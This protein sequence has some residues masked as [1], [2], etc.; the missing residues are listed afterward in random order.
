MPAL[1]SSARPSGRVRF[2]ALWFAV[3]LDAMR[4]GSGRRLRIRSSLVAAALLI[5][6]VATT[7]T[8]APSGLPRVRV[9]ADVRTAAGE[10]RGE[11]TFRVRASDGEVVFALF[12]NRF[13]DDGE[14]VNDMTRYYVYPDGTF[15]PGGIEILAV[16][17]RHAGG[18]WQ[19]VSSRS[20]V[21]PPWASGEDSLPPDTFL[22]VSSGSRDSIRIRFRTTLPERYGPFGRTE[23]G[24]T[25]IG[26]WYPSLVA[27]D[28]AG[29]WRF[30]RPPAL[31][32]T[33]A[34]LTLDAER[35]VVL[36][37]RVFAPSTTAAAA[38][39]TAETAPAVAGE[40][41]TAVREVKTR[42]LA[43][44]VYEQAV[45]T[46]AA[47]AGVRLEFASPEPHRADRIGFGPD[48]P[49]V[50][51]TQI[52]T[53][54]D[55]AP[56]A[57][58]RP[59]ALTIAQV[60]L[61][62]NLTTIS[63][64][65]VV[66]SDRA[67]HVHWLIRTFHDAQIAQAVY[68]AL[69][70]PR[71]L[72]CEAPGDREWVT[73][74]IAWELSRQFLRATE[75]RHE[76]TRK[77]IERLGIFAIVDRFER[78]PK[79]PFTTAFFENARSRDELRQSVFTWTQT[80]APAALAL[81][82]LDRSLG[83]AVVEEATRRWVEA[84]GRGCLPFREALREAAGSGTSDTHR[85]HAPTGTPPPAPSTS[86]NASV[87]SDASS[88]PAVIEARSVAEELD[89]ALAPPGPV[90]PRTRVDLN[91]APRTAR[92]RYQFVLDSADVDIS[93]SE[94]G[95]TALFNFR[96]RGNYRRGFALQ[97]WYTEK[98]YGF[99]TG[100]HLHW[101]TPND[102]SSYRHNLFA[103]YQLAEL[104]PSFTAD[105]QPD[106]RDNG[107]VAGFGLR[108][109][110]SDAWWHDNPTDKRQFRIFFDGYDPSLGG[111]W[112]FLRWGARARA[113]TTL[114]SPNTVLAGEL[115]T[116]FTHA[117]SDRGVPIQEQYSLGGGKAIRGISVNQQVARNIGLLRVELRQEI[118]PEFDL[119]F[120]DLVTYRRPQLRFFVDSGQADNSAGHALN[121]AHWAVG[122]GIGIGARYDF[123]GFFPGLAYIE[124][125]TRLDRD[126]TDFQFLFG[127]RQAF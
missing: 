113:T 103:F 39:G 127:T 26:G 114:F 62:W 12:P 104:L 54:L 4:A 106:V 28:E 42:S 70:R 91:L 57:L 116:G 11:A 88:P 51:R 99:R 43:L 125:A 15:E 55:H 122:A 56:A 101:G 100:P 23:Y 27:R 30:D 14:R 120:L 76:G 25:A 115:L 53:V 84:A 41:P 126:Q 97:P 5:S 61:R 110:Y 37:D 59:A 33:S 46:S 38:P 81:A 82:R 90:P 49:E 24:L 78:A 109:D 60:P 117:T 19:S 77:W 98:S 68:A 58:P 72:A 13:R 44:M 111:H 92:S 8:A 29:L 105:N 40:T 119:N 63:D 22:R 102:A 9:E 2:P 6:F 87:A 80:R 52:A 73:Q 94:F 69:V 124:V 36:G 7:A 86:P 96:E 10:I 31:T 1:G 75:P 64:G 32:L 34:A 45:L 3:R 17:G 18:P 83:D 108:Y 50:L 118:F 35:T 48:A 20:F 112:S 67:M 71:A 121:P 21:P 47:A 93:S 66:I 65:P 95:F 89:A 16:E 123:L 79:V 107:A 74:A 85:T